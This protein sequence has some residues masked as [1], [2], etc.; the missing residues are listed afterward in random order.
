[1]EYHR[2]EALV[3]ILV[4]LFVGA[5][6]SYIG[7]YSNQTTWKFD[8]A[9][10]GAFLLGDYPLRWMLGLRE[11]RLSNSRTIL[12]MIHFLQRIYLL[13]RPDRSPPWTRL[14]FASAW[15][16]LAVLLVGEVTYLVAIPAGAF[17]NR[18][19]PFDVT[20]WSF[21][22]SLFVATDFRDNYHKELASDDFW[23]NIPA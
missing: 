1:V 23:K 6:F 18:L 16:L 9:I 19:G 20:V 3:F 22:L 8:M 14:G 17:A 12:A 7:I 15:F 5:F 21:V 11:S 10:I 13:P 2:K 4:T